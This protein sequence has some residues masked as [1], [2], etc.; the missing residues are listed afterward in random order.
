MN[1]A[2]TR[3]PVEVTF[4]LDRSNDWI[5]HFFVQSK[6]FESNGAFNFKF[7]YDADSV[8]RQDIVFILAYTK[9]L[10]ADFLTRNT[11]NLV[12]HESHLPKG[13]GFSPVQWQILEGRNS[14]PVCLIEAA[15]QVD[16]GD[17]LCR[18]SIE[19][20]GGELYDEIRSLQASATIEVIQTFLRSYPDIFR[21]KQTG[22]ASF[23]KRRKPSDS[24]LDV[25]RS[26]REQF[27][28]MRIANN[29][30]WPLYFRM[31]GEKYVLKICKA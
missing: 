14:I 17:I 26:I 16:S 28:L 15:E 31:H 29:E 20:T 21:E 7:S 9:I 3:R 4:L 8:A 10:S 24:E 13:K 19:L 5:W 11:L 1:N 23:Y 6:A 18:S 12:V 27:N 25:D 30:H 22:D 2:I